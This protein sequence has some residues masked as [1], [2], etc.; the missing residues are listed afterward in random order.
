MTQILDFYDIVVNQLVGDPNLF[1]ILAY[2]L[3]TFILIK[4]KAPFS[5]MSYLL[6]AVTG[7]LAIQFP[8]LRW[9]LVLFGLGFVGIQIMRIRRE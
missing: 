6:I 1:V 7:V 9:G 4:S 8:V 5:V 3:I 2:M